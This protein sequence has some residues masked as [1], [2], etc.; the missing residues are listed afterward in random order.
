MCG[1]AGYCD[2]TKNFLNQYEENKEI[3]EKMGKTLLHR[4]PNDFGSYIDEHIAFSH[5]RLSVIDPIGGVQPMVK[6]KDSCRYVIVYNG[7]LYNTE[8]IRND[9]KKRGYTFSTSSDTEVV[10]TAY[11]AD[12]KRCVDYLNGIFSFAIWNS[13][14]RSVFL[15]RDRFGVKPF[16]YRYQDGKLLFGSEIKAILAYPT[17]KPIINRYSLCEIFGL[18]PARS[19]GCGIYEGISEIPPAYCAYFDYSGMKLYPYWEMKAK[20]HKESY[21]DTVEVVKDILFDAIERQLVSDVP[22]CTLLSG[23][24]DSSVVSAVAAHYFKQQGKVLDT[25]SFDY[26]DNNKNFKA[27]SFQPDQDRPFVDIMV[28]H[29]GSKHHYLEC[30]YEELYNC[31][32]D[33]VK[34]KDLPG[35]ADVDSSL[36]YFARKIKENHTVC[37]SGECADVSVIIGQIMNRIEI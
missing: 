16:F 17:V 11:I 25:Y 31:L 26:T 7:E 10:L 9:L 23:G 19:P 8:E 6:E 15:V 21:Q 28:K 18:G 12:G 13:Y 20:E 14:E 33:A 35:M 3:V 37:L 29:I 22:V 2:F 27:S 30:P 5:A 32:F 34:A 24:L 1:I 36:L 4:G